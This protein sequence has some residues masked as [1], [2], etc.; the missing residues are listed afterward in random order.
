MKLI[1]LTQGK[2]AKVDNEDYEFLNQWEWCYALGY[3][4]R[5]QWRKTNYTN[6]MMHRLIMQTPKGLFTDHIN[7]DKLDNRKINLRTCSANG[8]QQNKKIYKNNKSGFKG[9][10]KKKG[11]NGF[12]S[13]ICVNNKILHIG[14][15]RDKKEAALAYNE[16]AL[17]LHGEFANINY[18]K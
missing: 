1:E 8:N 3:A 11:K 2:F 9:V 12:V 5:G 16:K 7:G 13:Q 15:F 4:V 18:F 6:I 10:S 17:E 14:Y